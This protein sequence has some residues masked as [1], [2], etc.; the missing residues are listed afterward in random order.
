[1]GKEG[2]VMACTKKERSPLFKTKTITKI[3]EANLSRDLFI[4][5]EQEG[6]ICLIGFSLFV[7][8]LP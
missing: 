6:I 3:L 5:T 4:E 1:M 2:V 8:M 7:T